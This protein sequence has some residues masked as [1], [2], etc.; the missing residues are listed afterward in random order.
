MLDDEPREIESIQ[1]A[2][3][4]S[5]HECHGYANGKSLLRGLRAQR[6]DLLVL[7]WRPPDLEGIKMVR[8]LRERFGNRLPLLLTAGPEHRARLT[9]ALLAGADDFMVKPLGSAELQARVHALLRRAYPTRFERELVYG[10]YHFSPLTGT[11]RLHGEPVR[12]KQREY[13][14]ALLLFRN[15]GRL[16]PRA[17]LMLNVWGQELEAGSRSLDT[18]VSRLRARL[19]LRPG[20]GMILASVYGLGYRLEYIAGDDAESPYPTA[21]AAE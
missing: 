12:L 20:N 4:I 18:H 13:E 17:Y 15:I 5:G 14:L 2:M 1:R 7:G 19:D 9:T 8:R 16:L 3:A 10:P 21:K 11:I 6:Y